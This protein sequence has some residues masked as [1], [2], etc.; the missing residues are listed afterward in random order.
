[1]IKTNQN[2]NSNYGNKT[3]PEIKTYLSHIPLKIHVLE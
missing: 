2:N 3:F 1:M